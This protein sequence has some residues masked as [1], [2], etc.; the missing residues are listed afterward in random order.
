MMRWE[1]DEKKKSLTLNGGGKKKKGH[2]WKA[3]E[4]FN[5]P[6]AAEMNPSGLTITNKPHALHGRER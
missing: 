5:H 1:K 3:N 2:L 6:R 4:T